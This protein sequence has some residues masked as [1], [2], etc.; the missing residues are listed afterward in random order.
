VLRSARF[1]TVASRGS[2]VSLDEI[3]EL[4]TFGDSRIW[5]LIGLCVALVFTIQAV[6]T[7]TEGA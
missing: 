4:L 5:L 3:R 2:W 1:G 7:A 6:E